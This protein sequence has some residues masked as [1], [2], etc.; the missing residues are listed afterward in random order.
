MS[1]DLNPLRDIQELPPLEFV[2]S[3]G[4]L[5]LPRITDHHLEAENGPIGG[6]QLGPG[7]SVAPGIR[8]LRLGML[9]LQK[10][11]LLVCEGQVCFGQSQRGIIGE[12]LKSRIALIGN[13]ASS[14]WRFSA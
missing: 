5:Q 1:V 3:L 8:R 10:C 7:Q 2:G 4:V 11:G 14:S 12:P 6:N 9:L 13:Q